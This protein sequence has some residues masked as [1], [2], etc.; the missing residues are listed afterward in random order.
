MF[1]NPAQFSAFSSQAPNIEMPRVAHLGS[2]IKQITRF[3]DE[4]ALRCA[5]FTIERRSRA[6]EAE[7]SARNQHMFNQ[8]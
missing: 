1:L 5:R 4:Y 7:F 8:D 2:R 3:I 6:R